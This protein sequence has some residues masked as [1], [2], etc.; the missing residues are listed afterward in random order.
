[1]AKVRACAENVRWHGLG[2]CLKAGVLRRRAGGC[3]MWTRERLPGSCS[4]TVARAGSVSS[5]ASPR[6]SVTLVT[7]LGRG[8]VAGWS[9]SRGWLKSSLVTPRS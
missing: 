3:T 9:L 6:R 4:C 8:L 2:P 7:L 5:A 1:M